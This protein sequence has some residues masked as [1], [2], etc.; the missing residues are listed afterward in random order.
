[1]DH[2]W[3]TAES[4]ETPLPPRQRVNVTVPVEVLERWIAPHPRRDDFAEVRIRDVGVPVWTLIGYQQAT[5]ADY[6]RLAHDYEIPDEA[7][8]AAV[9]YYE[10][11]R[12]AIDARLAEN[13]A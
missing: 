11:H 12:P 13:A 1:M 10:L 7:A 2:G 8:R 5:G 6:R 4:Y 3:R 9:R